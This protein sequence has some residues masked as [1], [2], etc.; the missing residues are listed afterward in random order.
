M[1]ALL[2]AALALD[3]P[4]PGLA[5]QVTYSYNMDGVPSPDGTRIVFI[6]IVEGKEQLFLMNLDGTS[7]IQITREAADHEDPA[8][9]PDGSRIAFILIKDGSKRAGAS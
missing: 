9:S 5:Y 4:R 6:R 3:T 8:W 2:I 7:E 1:I